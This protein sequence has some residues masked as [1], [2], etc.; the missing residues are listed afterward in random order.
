[1]VRMSEGSVNENEVVHADII[2]DV[3]K[4]VYAYT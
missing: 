3:I 1:M 4:G 2:M